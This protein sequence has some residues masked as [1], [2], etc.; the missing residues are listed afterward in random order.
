MLLC[1]LRP[2]SLLLSMKFPVL[3]GEIFHAIRFFMLVSSTG[4]LFLSQILTAPCTRDEISEVL[5][6]YG[7]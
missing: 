7:K 2:F 6:C 4:N 3:L 1:T 5:H